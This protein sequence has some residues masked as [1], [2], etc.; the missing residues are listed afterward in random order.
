[1]WLWFGVRGS[2]TDGP[3]QPG[4]W[5]SPLGGLS[6][7]GPLGLTLPLPHKISARARRC[8]GAPGRNPRPPAWVIN[9]GFPEDI[10]PPPI[11]PAPFTARLP[12]GVGTWTPGPLFPGN[13]NGGQDPPAPARQPR[14]IRAGRSRRR[15][16]AAGE[17]GAGR[18]AGG[19]PWERGQSPSCGFCALFRR[20][21]FQLPPAR[22]PYG[23]RRRAARGGRG[24][25]RPACS[26]R[27]PAGPHPSP[28]RAPN[29]C[30]QPCASGPQRM[31]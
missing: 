21:L 9:Q 24:P 18:R 7:R 1:M 2:A 31:E 11:P 15:R 13:G 5:A 8:W 30:F 29:S 19:S 20:R 27:A 16:R 23:R 3:G 17:K 6:T 10:A 28:L 12:A 26:L 4:W 14:L 25:G 22:P